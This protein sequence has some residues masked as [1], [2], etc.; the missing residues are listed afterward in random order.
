MNMQNILAI[1]G[2][3]IVGIVLATITIAIG[4]FTVVPMMV[5]TANQL[6]YINWYGAHQMF[7]V[8]VMYS[9]WG[10]FSLYAVA[11]VFKIPKSKRA[12]AE[13]ETTG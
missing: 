5:E 3:V 11:L 6:N 13:E 1:F 9:F 2:K 7:R 10:I 8:V 4:N 12:P